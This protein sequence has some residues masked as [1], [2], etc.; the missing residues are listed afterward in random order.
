MSR[1]LA[2][3]QRRPVATAVDGIG[4]IDPIATSDAMAASDAIAAAAARSFDA[5]GKSRRAAAAGATRHPGQAPA[6]EKTLVIERFP[7]PSMPARR[8]WLPLCRS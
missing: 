1:W 2:L 4:G 8:E 5:I 7:A 6:R 3:A